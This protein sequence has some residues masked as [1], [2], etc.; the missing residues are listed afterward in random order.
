MTDSVYDGRRVRML[1]SVDRVTRESPALVVDRSRTGQRVG[2]IL[3]QLQATRGVPLR[4]AVEN[5]PEFISK[6]LDAWAHRHGVQLEFS[7]PGTPTDNAF[8]IG[9]AHV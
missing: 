6:A 4:I 3:E 2:A 5:E 8:K 7:R 1:T 9:R